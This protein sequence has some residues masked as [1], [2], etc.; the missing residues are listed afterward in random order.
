[1]RTAAMPAGSPDS[2]SVERVGVKSCVLKCGGRARTSGGG[3]W[4]PLPRSAESP[5]HRSFYQ[6]P[7]LVTLGRDGP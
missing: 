1:M 5:F 3:G 6:L 2:G 7:T 4:V